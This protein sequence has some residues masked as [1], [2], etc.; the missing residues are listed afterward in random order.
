[1]IGIGV[2]RTSGGGGISVT[3][4]Y[5][6]TYFDTLNAGFTSSSGNKYK[7]DRESLD[8][9]W[10]Q[11]NTA[12]AFNSTTARILLYS[13]AYLTMDIVVLEADLMELEANFTN[14]RSYFYG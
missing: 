2:K 9:M 6:G 11:L 5:L 3:T 1:M 7:A 14:A 12:K 10:E 8:V 13:N 4:T